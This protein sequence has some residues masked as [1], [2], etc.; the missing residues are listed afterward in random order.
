[1]I[2]PTTEMAFG[3]PVWD[4]HAC[5]ICGA[6]ILPSTAKLHELFH[7]NNQQ[8]SKPKTAELECKVCNLILTLDLD[9]DGAMILDPY[10]DHMEIH[11]V[12]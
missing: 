10:D 1:M 4:I 6:L 8:N 5:E 11:G 12:E 2:K 9:I 7:N 3:Q